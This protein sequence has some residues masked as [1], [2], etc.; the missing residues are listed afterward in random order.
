MT[1]ADLLCK[2]LVYRHSAQIETSDIFLKSCM[3]F[4]YRQVVKILLEIGFIDRRVV[5]Y[6]SMHAHVEP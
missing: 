2:L 1:W 4:E 3:L 5:K 6:L